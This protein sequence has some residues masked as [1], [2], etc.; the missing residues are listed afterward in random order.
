MVFLI[1]FSIF[2]QN[3]IIVNKMFRDFTKYEVYP[4]GKIW[5]YSH[6]KW[7]KPIIDN[8]GYQR[9]FLSDNEGKRKWYFVHRVVWEAVTGSPIPENLE[10]NHRS[11]VKTENSITNLELVSHKDNCNW[12]TRTER[13]AKG[14]SKANTNGKRSKTVGAFKNDELVMTFPSTQEASR[15]GFKQSAVSMCC[16]NCYS[17]EGNNVYRGFEWRYI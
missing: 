3:L 7:L 16:R 5:S 17:K 13:A 6:K 12:G 8:N 2:E 9:V 1:F 11:E 15:N 14:I 4:D 10:I